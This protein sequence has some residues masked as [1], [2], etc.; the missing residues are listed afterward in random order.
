MKEL[1]SR[2]KEKRKETQKAHADCLDDWEL[3]NPNSSA[4]RTWLILISRDLEN[5]DTLVLHARKVAVIASR[6][7]RVLLFRI[8][9]LEPLLAVSM[10]G[11]FLVA[12]VVADFSI[13]QA[14]LG[15]QPI[16][17]F[18]TASFLIDLLHCQSSPLYGVASL[19]V[20]RLKP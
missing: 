19:V 8:S 14:F 12:P 1:S 18:L 5:L 3:P 16:R 11:L 9:H 13:I 7:T 10:S 6:S 15:S 20:I 4:A 2:Q 17:D